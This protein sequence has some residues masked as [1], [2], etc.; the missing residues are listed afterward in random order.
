MY[1]KVRCECGV[2]LGKFFVGTTVKLD[3]FRNLYVLDATKLKRYLLVNNSPFFFTV[4]FHASYEYGKLDES[5]QLKKRKLNVSTL[6]EST[7]RVRFPSYSRTYNVDA[8]AYSSCTS[9]KR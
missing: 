8:H 3:V 6:L 1:R 2:P 5:S 7:E 9:R 4:L